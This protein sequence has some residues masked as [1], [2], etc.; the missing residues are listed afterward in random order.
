MKKTLL[1]C[2]CFTLILTGYSQNDNTTIKAGALTLEANIPENPKEGTICWTG[3]EFL[4][5]DGAKWIPING[6]ES[7]ISTVPVKIWSYLFQFPFGFSLIP[8]NKEADS[9]TGTIEGTG[10]ALDFEHSYYYDPQ[11]I[12]HGALLEDISTSNL[13]DG[14]SIQIIQPSNLSHLTQI[15]IYKTIPEETILVEPAIPPADGDIVF[16]EEIVIPEHYSKLTIS[17][18]NITRI[19]QEM[20]IDVFNTVEIVEPS[21]TI[22]I[23]RYQFQFPVGFSLIPG[24]GIDSYIGNINGAGISLSFDSGA[25]TSPSPLSAGVTEDVI[26]GNFRQIV[27]PVDSQN[28]FT[29]LFMYN[30]N[31]K[32]DDPHFYNRLTLRVKNITPAEQEMIIDIFNAVEIAN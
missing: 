7:A 5:Y 19:Q 27:K 30:I 29:K 32:L 8:E 25:Y 3:T 17:T 4:G 22:K 14:H 9:Y 6:N 26:Q 1:I 21:S 16:L 20:L 18:S 11:L 31:S 2:F 28:Y 23:G 12:I 13:I 24:N 10:I 15:I